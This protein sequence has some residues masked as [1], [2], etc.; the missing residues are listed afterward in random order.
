[1]EKT[2]FLR[3]SNP[4]YIFDPFTISD[5]T[6]TTCGFQKYEVVAT[7]SAL[8]SKLIYPPTGVDPA[9]CTTLTS[10]NTIEIDISDLEVID[11]KIVATSFLPEVVESA[12]TRVNIECGVS[13]TDITM[14]GLIT[15]DV[16]TV[17]QDKSKIDGAMSLL[18]GFSY[19]SSNPLCPIESYEIKEL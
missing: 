17:T 8:Q 14:S 19:S 2:I 15:N 16:L 13:S 7:N 6:F 9:S 3:D 18:E 11:F 5:P 1:L 10:C 12:E 4:V